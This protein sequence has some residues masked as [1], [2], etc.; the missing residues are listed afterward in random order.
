MVISPR[1]TAAVIIR[2]VTLDRGD[3]TREMLLSKTARNI[4]TVI[5]DNTRA[6]IP[7]ILLLYFTKLIIT[8][9]HSS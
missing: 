2:S 5:Q 8:V 6:G 4:P 9:I 1:F 7:S 3:N